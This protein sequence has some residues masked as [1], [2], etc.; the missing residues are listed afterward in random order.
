MLF[1]ESLG[2]PFF[3]QFDL[4]RKDAIEPGVVRDMKDPQCCDPVDM[5]RFLLAFCCAGNSSDALCNTQ[6]QNERLEY[7]LEKVVPV[8]NSREMGRRLEK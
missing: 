4:P 7:C 3:Y 6:A 1:K 2:F 5:V 8:A